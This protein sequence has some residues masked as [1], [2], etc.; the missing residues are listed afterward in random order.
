MPQHYLYKALAEYIVSRLLINYLLRIKG[1]ETTALI[2]TRVD[3]DY[4]SSEFV[5]QNNLKKLPKDRP[6]L[7]NIINKIPYKNQ[8]IEETEL[9]EVEIKERIINIIFNIAPILKA[10][11]LRDN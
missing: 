5:E 10:I 4:I 7:L 2:N 3:R 6:Y 1:R 11:I 9:L 8:I